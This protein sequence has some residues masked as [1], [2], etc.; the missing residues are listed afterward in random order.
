MAV[1]IADGK[2]ETISPAVTINPEEGEDVTPL[3]PGWI[4]RVEV[5][6]VAPEGWENMDKIVFH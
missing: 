4:D 5:D 2:I 6:K 1:A 3:K